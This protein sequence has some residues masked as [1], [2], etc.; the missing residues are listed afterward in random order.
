MKNEGKTVFINSHLLSEVE[1][2]SDSIAI[3]NKGKVVYSGSVE[4]LTT[5][6]ETYEV[7]INKKPDDYI[8][9]KLK[10]FNVIETGENKISFKIERE[11]EINRIMDILRENNFVILGLNRKKS[12]LEDKFISLVQRTDD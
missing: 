1:L 11:E 3:L 9:Y 12:S 2:I 8:L 6:K 7:E 5:S 4:A 10:D